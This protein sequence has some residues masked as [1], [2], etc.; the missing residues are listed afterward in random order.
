MLTVKVLPHPPI[1]RGIDLVV[2]ALKGKGH[3]VLPWTP[4][5]H[6]F[7]VDLINNIYAADGCTVIPSFPLRHLV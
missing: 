6:D 4:H 5:K 7:A 1:L 2:D 3:K